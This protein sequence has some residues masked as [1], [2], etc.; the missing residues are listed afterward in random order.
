M[1]KAREGRYGYI[2]HIIA[3]FLE[4]LE[5]ITCSVENLQIKIGRLDTQIRQAASKIF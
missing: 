2:I 3:V 4:L 1:L 5:K